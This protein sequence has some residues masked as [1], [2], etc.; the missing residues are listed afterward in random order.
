MSVRPRRARRVAGRAGSGLVLAL[1]VFFA[2]APAA[3]QGG[4]FRLQDL[5]GDVL[6]ERDLGEGASIFVV[7]A[8]WSPRCRDI[9]PRVNEIA[10]RWSRQARVLTVNYQEDRAAVEE[11]LAGQRLSS[12]TFLDTEGAFAKKYAVATLPVLIVLNEGKVA[13]RGKLPDDPH[14]LIGDLLR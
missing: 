6:T 13:Y 2:A 8:S 4:G 11:F 14:T 7:W 9:V 1:A 10:S 3:A 12:P 5:R